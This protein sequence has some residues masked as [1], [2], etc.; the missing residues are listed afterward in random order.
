MYPYQYSACHVSVVFMRVTNTELCYYTLV[1]FLFVSFVLVLLLFFLLLLLFC[2]CVFCT[3][4]LKRS[5]TEVVSFHLIVWLSLFIETFVFFC[6]FALQGRVD[7]MYCMVD[8]VPL[9]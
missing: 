9:L 2:S 1:N 6:A 5:S 8:H 3:Y 4:S 7:V